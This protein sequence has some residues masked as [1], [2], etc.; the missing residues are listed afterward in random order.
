MDLIGDIRFLDV[1]SMKYQ[2]EHTSF[3][4]IVSYWILVVLDK[5]HGWQEISTQKS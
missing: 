1:I 5:M 2:I 4:G 3:Q